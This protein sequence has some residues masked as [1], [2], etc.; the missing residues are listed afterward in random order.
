MA[1]AQAIV[2]DQ[3][4][5]RTINKS[6]T[7]SYIGRTHLNLYEIKVTSTDSVW[8]VN[9]GTGN[10]GINCFAFSHD[11]KLLVLGTYQGFIEV[12]NFKTK[13]KLRERKVHDSQVNDIVFTSSDSLLISADTDGNIIISTVSEIKE[14]IRKN[15]CT[16]VNA[17]ELL[18][19]KTQL[20]AT[21]DHGGN[22]VIWSIAGLEKIKTWEAHSSYI[23]DLAYDSA[24]KHLFSAGHDTLIK[25]WSFDSRKPLRIFSH[26]KKAIFSLD[27]SKNGKFLTSGGMDSSVVL[28]RVADAAVLKE[29]RGHKDYVLVVRFLNEDTIVSGSRDFTL[30]SWNIKHK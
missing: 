12:W 6:C 15:I 7:G 27:L 16:N 26:H 30:R 14:V 4:A 8:S 3:V 23:L 17:L 10:G 11:E 29:Y 2:R 5:I 22:I 9:I 21:G 28:W 25:K 19:G 20:F 1:S 24:G 18:S 13:E